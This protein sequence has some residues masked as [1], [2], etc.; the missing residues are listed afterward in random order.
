MADLTN[1]GRD[2]TKRIKINI[3]EIQ[4]S[5]CFTS[6]HSYQLN[7][8]KISAM[9]KKR[10][11]LIEVYADVKTKDGSLF[12]IFVVAVT[13]RRPGQLKLNSYAKSSRIKLLRKK[14]IEFLN[15]RILSENSK[16]LIYN[17][18]STDILTGELKKLANRVIPGIELQI[19]K[20]KLLKKNQADIGKA[21]EQIQ[22]VIDKNS[23]NEN[24]EARNLL[25]AS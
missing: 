5:S 11:S 24:P 22:G 25:S 19:S 6:F 17:I 10:Q 21:S 8:E 3:D 16:D 20:L 12:R 13:T 9:I 7:K 14:L 1:N 2:V 15:N 18:T 4:G 23:I